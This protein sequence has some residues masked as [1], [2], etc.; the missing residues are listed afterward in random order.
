MWIVL[1]GNYGFLNFLMPVLLLSLLDD[2]FIKDR[3]RS[4]WFICRLMLGLSVLFE[5]LSYVLAGVF[6]QWTFDEGWLSLLRSTIKPAPMMALF[7]VCSTSFRTLVTH[8]L[9]LRAVR[10]I[11]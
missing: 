8:P 7:F 10:S 2:D 9:V 11:A 6:E 3:T 5:V 4:V 1:T